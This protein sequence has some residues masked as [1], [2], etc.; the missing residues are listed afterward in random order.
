[1]IN[2]SNTNVLLQNT[3]FTSIENN[4]TKI[5]CWNFGIH[6][7]YTAD[8]HDF[9]YFNLYIKHYTSDSRDVISNNNDN[10]DLFSL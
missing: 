10:E 3:S 1:M 9:K 6:E 4:Y 7:I 5:N 2:Q 8:I